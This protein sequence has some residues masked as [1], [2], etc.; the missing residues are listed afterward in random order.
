MGLILLVY[1][2][3][4]AGVV[5]AVA[6]IEPPKGIWWFMVPVALVC[7]P[8]VLQECYRCRRPLR[9]AE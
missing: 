5:T 2:V 1:L 9:R 8:A 7:W 3:F 6:L 4:G